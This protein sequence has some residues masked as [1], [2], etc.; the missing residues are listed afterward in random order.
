MKN[1]L[2]F[3][4][5]SLNFLEDLASEAAYRRENTAQ[6]KLSWLEGHTYYDIR[7]DNS[8]YQRIHDKL[9]M[10]V[11]AG[12]SGT[13]TRMLTAFKLLNTGQDW[14]NFRLA[15]MGWMLASWDH[16]YT[17]FLEDPYSRIKTQW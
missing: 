16:P 14:L 4:R 13:T 1:W 8:W 17:K 5:M 6:K 3:F 11:V 10:P 9:R 2:I 7:P 15:I 12:V